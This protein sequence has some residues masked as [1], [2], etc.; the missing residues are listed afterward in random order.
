MEGNLY[1]TLLNNLSSRKKKKK[2]KKKKEKE[3]LYTSDI[4]S[5]TANSEGPAYE[6]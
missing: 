2:K 5:W 3:H 1:F 6:V 4:G